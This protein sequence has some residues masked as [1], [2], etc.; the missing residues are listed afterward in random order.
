MN[1][2]TYESGTGEDLYRRSLYTI[3]KR[4]VPPP[5]MKNFDAPS[6]SYCVVKRQNTSSPLQALSLMND[7]QFVEASR[8]LAERVMKMSSSVD[9][10]LQ[11][12]Y[13]L[14][15]SRNPSSREMFLIKDMYSK[16]HQSYQ[17]EN[18]RADELFSVG[19]YVPDEGLDKNQLA[20]HALTATMIMNLD[21][22]VVIR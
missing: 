19:E 10:R 21:A 20:A 3:W 16:L 1:K 13:R 4:T 15:T 22:S 14:L 5:T 12:T 17:E 6:R 2:G 8:A 7:P 18:D 11:L 9:H